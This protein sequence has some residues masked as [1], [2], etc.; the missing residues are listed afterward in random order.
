MSKEQTSTQMY[1]YNGFYF[2][3][4]QMEQINKG[5]AEGLD[6]S[7]YADPKYNSDQMSAI[8]DGL[9]YGLDV[10][11]Y[12]NPDLSAEEMQHY[13]HEL[14]IEKKKAL[15]EEKKALRKEKFSRFFNKF[16]FRKAL[17]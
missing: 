8:H 2:N 12:A 5:L 14:F 13:L 1:Q 7:I 4:E 6:V 17:P 9:E 15:K 10:S 11:V 16:L 3:E